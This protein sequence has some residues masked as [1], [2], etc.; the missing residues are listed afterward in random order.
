MS[1]RDQ[2]DSLILERTW[3][4][5]FALRNILCTLEYEKEFEDYVDSLEGQKSIFQQKTYFH[6]NIIKIF[7]LGFT[8]SDFFK[9]MTNA[10]KLPEGELVGA[11]GCCY[12][13]A[14]RLEIGKLIQYLAQR[15]QSKTKNYELAQCVLKNYER[16]VERKAEL[17]SR[18]LI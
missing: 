16:I 2:L 13:I 14:S 7:R 18:D 17:E 3:Q 12:S 5:I 1:V 4:C 6:L 11:T 8:W 9:Y 10:K 15:G